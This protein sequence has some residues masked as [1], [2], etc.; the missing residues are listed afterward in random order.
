MKLEMGKFYTDRKGRI[1]CCYL[2]CLSQDEP[3]Q[4]YC[5]RTDNGQKEYFYLDGRYDRAGESTFNLV[6]QINLPAP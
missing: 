5:I 3:C 4:A 1:W 6:Q 2:V